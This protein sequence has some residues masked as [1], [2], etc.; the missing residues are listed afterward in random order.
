MDLKHFDWVFQKHVTSSVREADMWWRQSAL[1]RLQEELRVIE[2]FD[3]VHDYASDPNSGD[4]GAYAFRQVRR[5][6]IMA[7]ISRLKASTPEYSNLARLTSVLL[8]GAVG[9]VTFHY[10][11]K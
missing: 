8:L 6:Q 3:R 5:S 1:T 4:N 10:L 2:L 7:E 9:Y 11:F